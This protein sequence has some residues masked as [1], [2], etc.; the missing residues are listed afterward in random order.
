MKD[1]AAAAEVVV[2]GFGFARVSI[3]GRFVGNCIRAVAV[4]YFLARGTV[5]LHYGCSDT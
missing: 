1:G 4:N 5:A 2:M 3:S